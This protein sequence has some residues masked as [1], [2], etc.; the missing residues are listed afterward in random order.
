VTASGAHYPAVGSFQQV[1][2]FARRSGT[3][4]IGN[5]DGITLQ[6]ASA[7]ANGREHTAGLAS[8]GGNFTGSLAGTFFGSSV[9]PVAETGGTFNFSS[10]A[11]YQAGGTFA[12]R[13]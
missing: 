1:W 3:A 9:H 2:N 12:A 13:R 6:G 5:F 7:C 11:G 4:T 8:A 10:A